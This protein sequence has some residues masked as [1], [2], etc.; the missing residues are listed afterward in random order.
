MS[1]DCQIRGKTD[2]HDALSTMCEV[3]HMEG[4]N[5][6][7]CDRCKKNTDTVLKTAISA[8]PDMLILSLKRFDLD[9]T[10]FETVKLNSRCEFGQTLNMK[11]YTLEGMEAIDSAG[12]GEE[13]KEDPTPMDTNDDDAVDPLSSLPDD[14]YE[15]KLAGVLVHAGVA[16]GGHYYSFIRDRTPAGA[17]D[18]DKWYRFDD[19]DVTVFDPSSIEAECFGGK[20]KRETKIHSGQVH[21][22]ESEQFA[23]ALML[24]YE[25]VKRADQPMKVS[26]DEEHASS[27]KESQLSKTSGY[28][29]FEPD[30]RRSNATHRW[31]T[32]LFDGEFHNF[33][34][35]LLKRSGRSSGPS[36]DR[37]ETSPVQD[38][39]WRG[40]VLQL[41]FS[42]FL[43]VLLYSAQKPSLDE[44]TDRL[45]NIITLDRECA[46]MFVHDLAART[47]TVSSN[48]LRTYTSD[49]P[50]RRSRIAALVIFASAI[51]TCS[52]IDTE[53]ALLRRWA[54]ACQEQVVSK[55]GETAPLPTRLEG[56]WASLED[57]KCISEGKGSAIGKI[58]SYVTTLLEAAPRTWRYNSEL[59]VLIRD[60]AH[61][62]GILRSALKEALVPP[63]LLALLLRGRATPEMRMKFP[64]A[65]LSLE[66]ADTQIRME[67]SPTTHMMPLG[68]SQIAGGVDIAQRSVSGGHPSPVDYFYLFEAFACLAGMPGSIHA[69]L[70][71]EFEDTERNQTMYQLT[72]KAD[73]AFRTI[74]EE[75]CANPEEGMTKQEMDRHLSRSEAILNVPRY[76]LDFFKKNPRL[77]L[78]L[79]ISFYRDLARNDEGRV[80]SCYL[81][82]VQWVV[83]SFYTYILYAL[84]FV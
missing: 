34:L 74:F 8:L 47:A 7:F 16:Q 32:F 6:V 15:Y 26:T 53:E 3:E 71:R 55:F 20:V 30:V 76:K 22:V 5:K 81:W 54:D 37:M 73:A 18:G 28:D 65:A 69:P 29:A 31:Q 35:E 40:P 42:F 82:D 50:D 13:G 75:A 14:D 48:W 10:T 78:G 67:S 11:R 1:I 41:L 62:D 79:F 38:V 77:E 68:T 23:N 46:K 9:Y 44:W 72:D 27:A 61:V 59:C 64:G 60:L 2:V 83:S 70:I 45:S 21:A 63:R 58:I 39:S 24:F 33:L 57:L 36:T 43:D 17:S 56:S 51:K 52:T 19:E 66:A 84:F 25:K 12:E 49:C 4:N 80:S